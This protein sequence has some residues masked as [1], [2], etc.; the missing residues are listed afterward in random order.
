[1]AGHSITFRVF[2][3][4]LS[5]LPLLLFATW[6]TE[7]RVMVGVNN[8]RKGTREADTKNTTFVRQDA[9]EEISSVDNDTTTTPNATAKQEEIPPFLPIQTMHQYKQWH[10]V[11][12]LE[13]D[14]DNDSRQFAIVYYYCPNRAGNI[15]HNMFISVTWAIITNRTILW[16]YDTDFGHR[17]TVEDCQAVLKR[18]DWI[19]SWD[20]WSVRLQLDDPAPIAMDPFRLRYDQQ[21]RTVIFPQIADVMKR[22]DNFSRQE[23]RQDPSYKG[24]FTDYISGLGREA[25]MRTVRLYELGVDFLFGTCLYILRT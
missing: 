7:N 11:H 5:V 19:P 16:K 3:T 24:R 12:A 14:P 21:H 10:S 17:N 2:G 22:H 8:R 9:P 15:L 25:K 6:R 20:E 23:W 1:M 4:I 18:A 13:T